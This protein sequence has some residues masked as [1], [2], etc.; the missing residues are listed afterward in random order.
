MTSCSRYTEDE[1]AR[2]SVTAVGKTWN[3][4]GI[5]AVPMQSC[6]T[7]TVPKSKSVGRVSY[8]V[9]IPA[10]APRQPPYTG[11]RYFAQDGKQ[12]IL[13]LWAIVHGEKSLKGDHTDSSINAGVAVATYS[14]GT[15]GG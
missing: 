5:K 14:T 1:M 12:S 7:T 4:P 8:L 15:V 13:F 6:K 9:H 2:E 10:A 3:P 11:T